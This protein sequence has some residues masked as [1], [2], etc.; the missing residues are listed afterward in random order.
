MIQTIKSKIEQDKKGCENKYR[1]WTCREKDLLCP[2][3]QATLKAHQE[4]LILAEKFV[5]KLKAM[6]IY[7]M[8]PAS[9]YPEV[10]IKNMDTL[11]NAETDVSVSQKSDDFQDEVGK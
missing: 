10:L 5:S 4:D 11:A 8:P 1:Y 7:S 9:V 6:I 2:S 3:C